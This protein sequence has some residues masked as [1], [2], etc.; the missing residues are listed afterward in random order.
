MTEKEQLILQMY[1]SSRRKKI[2]IIS[3]I[4]LLIIIVGLMFVYFIISF[5][6][7]NLKQNEIVIEYGNQYKPVIDDF[8]SFNDE[9]TKNNTSFECNLKNEENKDY[10]SVGEYQVNI[11]HIFTYHIKGIRI[12][13]KTINKT[14]IIIV[15][16]TT[17]P[18]FTENCPSELTLMQVTDDSNIEDLSNL[19][20]AYDLSGTCDISI[21][22]D[23]VDYKTAGSYELD[24]IAT[25]KSNNA[26]TMKCNVSIYSPE[27]SIDKKEIILNIGDSDK[28]DVVFKG[29][30]NPKFINEND[31]VISIDD[32]GNIK[33]LHEGECCVNVTC[34]GITEKCNIK[35]NPKPI[36]QISEKETT[37]QAISSS[38]N[39]ISSSNKKEEAT[40]QE[41]TI[42]STTESNDNTY[43]SNN[44]KQE[45]INNTKENYPNK[46]FLFVDGY[47]MENVT[48]AATNYLNESGRAG[49]CFPLQNSEGIYI[50][51]RVVFSD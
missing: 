50:G 22:D 41:T 15:K 26:T 30:E 40:I 28:I 21:K 39:N 23:N 33:A 48:D 32:S 19:F 42:P 17:S 13:K 9:I 5:S 8:V 29:K 14:A 35:V 37:K 11:T 2:I 38:N 49:S 18:V 47:T 51:M 27:L 36:E 45:E 4:L 44:H 12:F 3:I 25:D 7:F 43:S 10:A 31:T 16:D 46:D 34:N 1:E 20:T 24:V 6:S